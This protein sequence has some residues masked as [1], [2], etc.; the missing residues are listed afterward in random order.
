MKPSS[1]E[2]ENGRI[3]LVS[4]IIHIAM[5]EG[6]H[7]CAERGNEVSCES[8]MMFLFVVGV[9]L[10]VTFPANILVDVVGLT[11]AKAVFCH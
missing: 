2:R 7:G 10:Q 11:S 4:L 9:P 8:E 1:L 6:G 3:V 5:G